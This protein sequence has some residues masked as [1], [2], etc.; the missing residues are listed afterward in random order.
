MPTDVWGRTIFF[1]FRHSR[2]HPFARDD[3][4]GP[5]LTLYWRSYGDVAGH[6]TEMCVCTLWW[7]YCGVCVAFGK[8]EK[9][10]RTVRL[11]G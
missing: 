1:S 2:F 7:G 8:G 6:R 3:T 4:F 9:N 10:D 11:L 5:A